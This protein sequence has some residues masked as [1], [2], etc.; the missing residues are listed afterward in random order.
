MAQTRADQSR[1]ATRDPGLAAHHLREGRAAIRVAWLVAALALAASLAGLLLEGV[2][3][4]AA[5]TAE[6]FR[7]YD[8]VTAVLVVPS[9]VVAERAARRGSVWAQLSMT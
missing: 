8:L 2:Y 4:G 1:P 3:T 7:G 9:L 5:S 6:M